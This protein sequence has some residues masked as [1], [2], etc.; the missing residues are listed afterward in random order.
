MAVRL[1]VD[2]TIIIA[3]VI[4]IQHI[5][6]NWEKCCFGDAPHPNNWRLRRDIFEDYRDYWF[7][8]FFR[9]LR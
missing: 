4:T 3:R 5:K 9:C 1:D 7:L 6:I 8:W 2:S